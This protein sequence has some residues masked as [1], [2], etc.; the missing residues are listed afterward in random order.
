MSP[1]SYPVLL[2][3]ALGTVSLVEAFIGKARTMIIDIDG[4][5]FYPNEPLPGGRFTA[6]GLVEA[7]LSARV[8][9]APCG[10]IHSEA[11]FV[12][13]EVTVANIGTF[14]FDLKTIVVAEEAL[15]TWRK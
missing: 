3:T 4:V 2:K 7:Y 11:D 14:Y 13:P 12:Q 6:R 15:E 10:E 1:S 8:F 9:T 5:A